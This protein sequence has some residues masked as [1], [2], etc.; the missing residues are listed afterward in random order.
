MKINLNALPVD[1]KQ[2]K[3]LDGRPAYIFI[4]YQG[5]FPTVW[6]ENNGKEICP[7]C[8]RE[9]HPETKQCFCLNYRRI[10]ILNKQ[11][12]NP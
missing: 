4:P 1:A 7:Y 11:L 3:V 9:L 2:I 5:K 6:H 10:S 12:E 8:G